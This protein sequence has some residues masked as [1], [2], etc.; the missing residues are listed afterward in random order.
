MDV[1][2]ILNGNY[3]INQMIMKLLREHAAKVLTFLLG[4][5]NFKQF[6]ENIKNKNWQHNRK[7]RFD[8]SVF[9]G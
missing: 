5:L 2:S 4:S 3:N 7:A 1:T 8:I 9:D 6:E